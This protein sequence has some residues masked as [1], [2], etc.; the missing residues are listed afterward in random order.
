[1]RRLLTGTDD[2]G[3]S[4]LVEVTEVVPVAVGDGHGVSVA[5]VHATTE[6]PPPP[7]PVGQGAFV[8]VSLDP[9]VLR[10]I[11]VEHAPFDEGDGPTTSSTLHHIDALD[12][13]F[14]HEGSGE[15]LLGDGAHPVVAGDLI[16]MPGVDHA[17]K[18]GPGGCRLVVVSV[19][20]PL[21]A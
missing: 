2:Q 19:G 11:V 17:M 10:W 6:S 12:L 16:V 1:V 14:V 8:P 21:P 5:R 18:A 15:L 3:R 7:R 20:T 9:G 4:C 13:V